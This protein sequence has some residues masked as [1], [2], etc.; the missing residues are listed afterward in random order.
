MSDWSE[1]DGNPE[2]PVEEPKDETPPAEAV[3]EPEKEPEAPKEEPKEEPMVPQ[4]LL[5]KVAK[6]IREKGRGEVAAAK[7]RAETLEAENQQLKAQI[8][9]G[10]V[11]AEDQDQK[12]LIA[13]QVRTEFLNR[14]DVYGHEKYGQEYQD[15]L[16]LLKDLNDPVLSRKIQGASDPADTLIKEMRRVAEDLEYGSDP[17]ERERKKLEA[18]KAEWRSEWEAEMSAKVR[19]SGNQ[20]T[21]VQN[22]RAAGG[23]AAPDF[24]P[25]TWETGKGALPK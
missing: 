19:A 6:S 14:Q 10:D 15:A 22:V 2:A 9:Q 21:D 5:G 4:K 23:D 16:L 3:K 13:Q 11:P 25:D 1:K 18:K 17:A 20:P 12:A 7:A 24:V 8:N